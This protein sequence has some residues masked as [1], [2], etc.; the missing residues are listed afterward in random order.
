MKASGGSLL[1]EA[2][3]GQE[4]E[5]RGHHQKECYDLRG[6]EGASE[7]EPSLETASKELDDDPRERVA[8]DVRP[9]DLSVELLPPREKEEKPEERE[10][11]QRLVELRRM[12]GDVQRHADDL[13]RVGVGEGH[14]PGHVRRL[15]VT[16]ARGE[17]SQA[18]N[19]V[20]EG[21]G[22]CQDV[23]HEPHREPMF[24][25]EPD[26]GQYRGH[27]TAIEDAAG[28]DEAQRVVLVVLPV[29]DQEQKLRPNQGGHQ[30]IEAE[31]HHEVGFDP[32]LAS[33][34][35]RDLQR[36]EES[37]GEEEAVR[38]EDGVEIQPEEAHF[39]EIKELRDQLGF[40]PAR[41]ARDLGL[42]PARGLVPSQ[43]R[44]QQ[45]AD[46][47]ADTRVG[48]LESGPGGVAVEG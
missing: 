47:D 31:V 40:S 8:E 46:P 36:D 14:G 21:D 48:D 6:G 19:G 16:A 27:E 4:G 3:K 12:E 7:D 11:H 43:A 18:S 22:G 1:R 25:E 9:E 41:F 30:D 17:A 10:L 42:G 24:A 2:A 34:D 37:R 29:H 35:R 38:M 26:R 13:S 15:P 28:A 5:R 44:E 39:T 45:K 33:A 20:P 32:E 23:R